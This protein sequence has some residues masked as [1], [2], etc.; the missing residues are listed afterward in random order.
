MSATLA[1]VPIIAK[2]GVEGARGEPH[3]ADD[4]C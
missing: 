3:C 1:M 2:E 4:C